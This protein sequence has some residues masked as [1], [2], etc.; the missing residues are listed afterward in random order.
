MRIRVT[1]RMVSDTDVEATLWLGRG[2][3]D[4]VLAGTVRTDVRVWLVLLDRV[5]QPYY[6]VERDPCPECGHGGHLGDI[7]LAAGEDRDGFEVACRCGAPPERP[8]P[9]LTGPELADA[10]AWAA[11]S[12]ERGR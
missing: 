7:C 4:P 3:Q 2:D 8:E 12:R 9:V 11:R 1:E 10:R 5:Q 6:L